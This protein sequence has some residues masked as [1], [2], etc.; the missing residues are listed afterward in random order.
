MASAYIFIPFYVDILGIE[1]FGLIGFYSVVLALI[2]LVDVGLS[3]TFA[4]EASRHQGSPH[5]LDL[6]VTIERLLAFGICIVAA[7]VFI[8]ADL[9]ATKWLTNH[10]GIQPSDI[11][12]SIRLM[13]LAFIPQIMIS[14]YI[15]GLLG[16]QRQELANG[17]QVLYITVRSGVVVAPLHFHPD[18]KLFFGWQLLS[19]I[20]FLILIRIALVR[21]IGAPTF[22]AGHFS[23]D[24]LFPH[25]KF[26]GG[27]L[28]IAIISGISSQL[29]KIV[30]SKLFSISDLGSYTLAWTLAQLPVAITAPILMA[31][32]PKLT[33][34]FE[35]AE[36]AQG[37]RLYERSSFMIAALST[38]SSIGLILFAP[39]ILN[40][41]L[42][43]DALSEE[44]VVI[45]RVLTVGSLFLSLAST[46]FYFGLTRGHTKTS[47]ALGLVTLAFSVPLLLIMTR[48]YGLIGAAIP[49]VLV[50]AAAFIVVSTTINKK[51]YSRE[52][53]Q[54][55]IRFT[56]TPML[57][58]G[59][60]MLTAR[61]VVDL[62]SLGPLASCL[63]AFTTG[64]VVLLGSIGIVRESKNKAQG[65]G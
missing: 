16:L 43:D 47:I 19:N 12:S 48:S 51:Y 30:V 35:Q 2:A 23:L 45:V 22:T 28:I 15:S 64:L 5:L 61:V 20:V 29:D 42:P 38:T 13:A 14:L 37:D 18:I 60:A 46:P 50:N 40:I 44:V 26:A 53:C 52:S 4:R 59:G 1:S 54:W 49:W 58:A 17:L 39:E 31:L 3:T 62:I 63:V 9:I 6:L 65:L 24:L 25:L 56:L 36:G 41:W 27:M 11:Q 33:R 21:K 8:S 32:Y 55:L 57:I 10:S 7:T 34:L